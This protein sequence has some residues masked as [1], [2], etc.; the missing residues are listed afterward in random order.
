[1][2]RKKKTDQ[3]QPPEDG[4]VFR[5]AEIEIETRAADDGKTETLVRANHRPRHRVERD[6]LPA[7]HVGRREQGVGARP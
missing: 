3:A 2:G 6:A 1:M 4:R 5:E 7:N